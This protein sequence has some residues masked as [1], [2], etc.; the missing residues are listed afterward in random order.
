MAD[1][2]G[3]TV[4]HR[5]LIFMNMPV[6]MSDPVGMKISVVVMVGHGKPLFR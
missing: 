2:P 1:G 6:G 3:Q 5:L 4:H